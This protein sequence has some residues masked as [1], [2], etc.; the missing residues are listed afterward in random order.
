MHFSRKQN[1]S[2]PPVSHQDRDVN[3]PAY[4]DIHQIP[5]PYID[6]QISERDYMDIDI[7]GLISV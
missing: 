4:I 1:R 5:D 6:I 7:S 3:R 2:S